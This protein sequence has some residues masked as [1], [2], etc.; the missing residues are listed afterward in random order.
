MSEAENKGGETGTA[1]TALL[2]EGFLPEEVP[3]EVA[4]SSKNEN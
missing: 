4:F 2:A 1:D 3:E